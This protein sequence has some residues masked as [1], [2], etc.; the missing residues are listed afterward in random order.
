MKKY[1]RIILISSLLLLIFPFLGFPE[2]W[3]NLYVIVL[4]FIIGSATLFLRHKSGI[5]QDVDEETSLQ[6][7][8]KELQERFKEQNKTE[9]SS[10]QSRISDVVIN[11][12]D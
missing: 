4:A 10:K 2:L 6:D 8:V 3:E 9:E 11:N 12:H 5:I 7:Y 1:T